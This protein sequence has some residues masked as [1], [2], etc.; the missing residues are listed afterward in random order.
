MVQILVKISDGSQSLKEWA[1]IEVQG[2]LECNTG[3]TIGGKLIGNLFFSSKERPLL[4]IG[5]QTLYGKIENIPPVAVLK[6]SNSTNILA[7]ASTANG[8]QH[9]NSGYELLALVKKKIA[10]KSRPK[11]IV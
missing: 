3:D 10:F 4:I 5:Y 2:D 6:K 9:F 11:P 8:N 7:T 1:L